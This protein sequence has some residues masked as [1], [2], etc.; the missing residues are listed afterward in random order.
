[1]QQSPTQADKVSDMAKTPSKSSTKTPKLAE[2]DVI[3]WL[4]ANPDV[5]V[6]HQESLSK[7]AVPAKGGNILSLHAARAQRA[8]REND[9]LELN[10]QR[11]IR[12]AEVNTLIASQIFGA[13]LTMVACETLAQLR[14]AVQTS[15]RDDLG[16]QATRLI[17]CSPQPTPT[18]L[19]EDEIAT[20]FPDG[21]VALRRL[22]TAPE[23][24]L[25]GPK[26]KMIASD[27]L[28]K[29]SHNGQTIGM[30]ALGSTSPDHFHSGQSTEMARFLA[31]VM[32]LCLHRCA[33]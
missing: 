26:G 4:S 9:K 7:L 1:M 29:L 20:Y 23:R 13:V 22:A 15:L 17:L 31:Q 30:L 32:S 18:T 12:R 3:A 25:Y 14:A 11:L 21:P 10:H 28:L 16:V 5:F 33:K 19:A 6:R 24:T 27:C 2:T 8:E